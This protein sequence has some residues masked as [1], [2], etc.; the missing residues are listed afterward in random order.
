MCNRKSGEIK[1]LMWLAL[2]LQEEIHFGTL[3]ECFYDFKKVLGHTLN[4]VT[5]RGCTLS[6]AFGIARHLQTQTR[7]GAVE[8]ANG[9]SVVLVCIQRTREG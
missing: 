2:L 6:L 5:R 3:T 8:F 7:L 4:T 9:S 1:S